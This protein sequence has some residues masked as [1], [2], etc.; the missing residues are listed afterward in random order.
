VPA[1]GASAVAPMR[2]R[3]EAGRPRARDDGP[4]V[5][6]PDAQA[7]RYPDEAHDRGSAATNVRA[8]TGGA[9]SR[10]RDAAPRMRSPRE[11]PGGDAHRPRERSPARDSR[12]P[13]ERPPIDRRPDDRHDRWRRE[14]E[15]GPSVV[16]F[17][18]DIPAFMM[19][20]RRPIPAPATETDA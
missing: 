1:L 14:E 15:T 3:N 8:A 9:A 7:A 2:G 13:D 6:V 12:R 5:R 17:G 19:T 11:E 20:R 18:D 16:G 10:A 4:S